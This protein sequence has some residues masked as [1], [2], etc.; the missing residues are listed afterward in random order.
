MKKLIALVLTAIMVLSLAAVATV[1]EEETTILSVGKSYTTTAPNRTDGF[2]DDGIK[3]TDGS[4]GNEDGG[5]TVYSGWNNINGKNVLNTYEIVVDLGAAT[6]SNVFTIYAAGGNWGIAIFQ[7]ADFYYSNDGTNFTSIGTAE[8]VLTAGTGEDGSWSTYT[9]TVESETDVDAR[10]IKFAC[11]A[12]VGNCFCWIDEVEAA[13][14]KKATGG[15]ATP[16][17]ISHF[18]SCDNEGSGAIFTEAYTGGAW[19]MHVAFKPVAGTNAFEIVEINANGLSN[20]SGAALAIP[21]GGFVWAS[22]YGNDYPALSMTGPDYTTEACTNCINWAKDNFAVGKKY[23]F[24]GLDLVNKTIP[25]TTPTLDWYDD[26]YVCTATIAEYVPE[27][28]E[29]PIVIDGSI[30]DKGWGSNWTTVNGETGVY[31]NEPA[32]TNSVSYKYQVR[33]DAEKLYIAIV[34]DG[35][36]TTAAAGSN[37]ANGSGL[38]FRVWFHNGDKDATVYTNFIDACICADGTTGYRGMLNTQ[39]TSNKAA[40]NADTTVVAAAKIAD[41]KSYCEFSIDLD[42]IGGDAGQIF[43]AVSNKFADTENLCLFAPAIAIGAEVRL[44]NFPYNAWYSEG[45]LKVADV[46]KVGAKEAKYITKTADLLEKLAAGTVEKVDCGTSTVTITTGENGE[47]IFTGAAQWPSVNIAF[48]APITVDVANT[49]LKFKATITGDAG[50]GARGSIHLN[51]EDMSVNSEDIFLHQFSGLTL[52][53]SGDAGAGSVIELEVPLSELAFCNYDA[54]EGYAGKIAI[55]SDTVTFT[56]LT[57]FA[58]DGGIITISEFE[59]VTTTPATGDMGVTALIVL[60]VVA[61][62]GTGI[63]IKAKH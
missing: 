39:K 18:N 31:Q 7:T 19:W 32:G 21:E 24:T 45:A 55:E 53:G 63:V 30:D 13:Y 54:S 2:N 9:F 29:E 61:M 36:G 26:N 22:N 27:A 16:F 62:I 34:Y 5:T 46:L 40:A 11:N 8:P 49:T 1:A 57:V 10:Y 17:Y 56:G 6:K 4:K 14:K 48:D 12:S 50:A 3:L 47:M 38:N 15:D 42:E 20:G 23:V 51:G 25:T 28:K 59:L 41:G 44:A 43:F 33:K 35:E 58:C 52:D 37:N 60:A